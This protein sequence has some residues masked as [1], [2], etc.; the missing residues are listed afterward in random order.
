MNQRYV[1]F[2]GLKGLLIG[3]LLV[4]VIF[5]A[6]AYE[7]PRF[8]LSDADKPVKSD[9]I[10]LFLG[11]VFMDREKEAYRLLNQG[12]ARY[13]IIPAFHRVI[14]REPLPQPDTISHTNSVALKM[15][16]F[17]YERTHVEELYAKKIMDSLGLKSAIMVSSPYHMRRIR[18]IASRTFGE[19]SRFFADMS[20][21]RLNMT[22]VVSGT[23]GGEMDVCDK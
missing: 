18:L 8:L 11:G 7:A 20:P 2:R 15:I 10:I 5:G 12:Y 4:L 13:L 19:Q 6:A 1:L 21:H 22:R 23:W 16:P 9:A 3:L 17:F 14:A